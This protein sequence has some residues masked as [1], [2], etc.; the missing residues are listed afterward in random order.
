MM[1]IRKADESDFPA[2][3]EIM[4]TSASI[5]ELNGFVPQGALDSRVAGV[6]TKFLAKL[7]KELQHR[8]HGVIV[9]EKDGKPVGFTYCRYERDCIGIEEMDVR[10]EYQQQGI[11]KAL[12]Q[13]I[14]KMAR[15]KGSKRL[16]TGTS[17]NKEGKPWK[18][19]WFWIHMGFIDTGRRKES[20]GLKYA[21]LVKYL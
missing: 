11:G 15:E 18:A 10:K 6:S 8:E 4:Q 3:V 7:R 14:E 2:I 5:E 16:K 19:Y 20:S 21:E 9:T 1:L 12:V 13:Y 17:I